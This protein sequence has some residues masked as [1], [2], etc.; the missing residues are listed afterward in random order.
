M[1]TTAILVALEIFVCIVELPAYLNALGFVGLL[2]V[3]GSLRADDVQ[4][5]LPQTMELD[6]RGFSIDL[7][8]SKTTGP[9]KRTHGEGLR[10]KAHLAHRA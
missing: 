8:R 3:W 1:F 7:A 4:G 2:M 6:E 5:L 9:D 10:G